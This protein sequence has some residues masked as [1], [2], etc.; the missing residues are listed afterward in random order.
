VGDRV[1]R[2]EPLLVIHRN[3]AGPDLAWLEPRLLTAFTI[4]PLPAAPA[5]LIIERLAEEQVP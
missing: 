5:P 3:A 4:G 2:G 1:A